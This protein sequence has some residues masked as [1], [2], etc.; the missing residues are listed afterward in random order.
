MAIKKICVAI[1]I[2]I[3]TISSSFAQIE[4]DAIILNNSNELLSAVVPIEYGKESF[5]E[6]INERTNGEREPIGLLLSGGSARA[7]AHIGVL[8]YLEEMDI[9]PDYIISNSM[10]SIVGV[11]Y[12]AGLT[13]NQILEISKS[14][15]TSSL[16]DITFPIA[17]GLLDNTKF[18]S[19]LT[20]YIAQDA[21]LEDLEI[22]IMVIAE[23]SATKRQVHIMEGDIYKALSA[24]F[25]IPVYFPPV[26]FNGHM[27]LDGGITNLVPLDVAFD[28]SSSVIVSTTFY[29]GSGINLRNPLSLLNIT[30]DIGKRRQGVQSIL[31]HPEAIWIRCNVEEFSFMDFDAVDQLAQRGYE[32]A[33]REHD[34]LI[35]LSNPNRE[36]SFVPSEQFNLLH[37]KILN[38]YALYNS[39][40]PDNSSHQLFF[41]IKNF[42]HQKDSQNILRDETL[43]GLRYSYSISRFKISLLGGFAFEDRSLISSY[44]DFLLTTSIALTPSVQLS[45][46]FLTSFDQ[47]IAPRYYLMGSLQV[48]QQFLS[49]LFVF[50]E[51]IRFEQ[52]NDTSFLSEESLLDA[53]LS[54]WY[55]GPDEF[56]LKLNSTISY[57]ST[58]YF[59]RHYFNSKMGFKVSLPRDFILC[60]TYTGRYAF[61]GQGD[62]PFYSSDGFLSIHSGLREQ[63]RGGPSTNNANYLIVTTLNFDWQPTFF[64]PT[65]GEMLIFRDSSMGVFGQFLWYESPQIKPYTIFGARF[66]STV[67]LLGLKELPTSL[68]IGYDSLQR[69]FI[70]GLQFGIE[71]WK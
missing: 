59:S 62:I 35:T 1:I 71:T 46:N 14:L 9:T 55:R 57:Q 11:M 51:S 65:I 13:S 48:R 50:E 21:Q 24:S 28:Y 39:I 60:G 43:F 17:G 37:E 49:R 70:I 31:A 6:R 4:T 66:R 38:D 52:Q 56:P 16:F 64:R 18:V 47:G 15:D 20:S 67:S 29:E 54:V 34:E 68:Y 25:A 5:I 7:F 63:G 30:L 23:D 32:S 27:L 40:I 8:R 41:G 26:K 12:A 44:P 19:F 10:G 45:G 33:K 42:P 2:S 3:I 69:G 36:G 58:Q 22:P 53:G 61:D